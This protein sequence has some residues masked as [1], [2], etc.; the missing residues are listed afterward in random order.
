MLVDKSSPIPLY[1]QLAELLREQ[2]TTGALKPGDQLP[3]DRE[4]AELSGISRMTA[5]QA[6]LFLARQGVLDVRPGVGTFVVQPKLTHDTLHLLGFTEE[7]MRHGHT[8]VSQVLE[9]AVG[10]PPQRVITEL[11]L[12]ANA[13]TVKIV[14]L[15]LAQ[16]TPLLLE[17]IYVPAQKCPG[18]ENQDL[19][20]N[21][22]YTLLQEHYG[23]Q[24]ARA[25]Q[26]L[27]ATTANDYEAN[28]FSL[29]PGT[30]MILVEGVTYLV[31]NRPFEYF[32]TLYRGDRFKFELSSQRNSL[33]HET[34]SMPLASV[35]LT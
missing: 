27:E 19:V 15:R 8:A 29:K 34:S 2:I 31:D 13:P 17:T 32:K 4:L 24:L 20:T 30:A 11:N 26:T 1:Y 28:L 9:Q 25:R 23:L 3:S 5:R 18:L 6:V 22:L 21:S 12:E 35:V 16:E 33:A 10:I 7:M 14:R